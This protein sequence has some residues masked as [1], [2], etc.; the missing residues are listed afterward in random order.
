M[1][2]ERQRIRRRNHTRTIAD[3]RDLDGGARLVR[4][5]W[6]RCRRGSQSRR[7]LALAEVVSA[8]G[9]AIAATEC[10]AGIA[11]ASGPCFIGRALARRL[12]CEALSNAAAD[13][14]LRSDYGNPFD[15]HLFTGCQRA[16]LAHIARWGHR[17]ATRCAE[18]SVERPGTR[19]GPASRRRACAGASPDRRPAAAV[20]RGYA[21]DAVRASS[22]DEAT[23]GREFAEAGYDVTR[24]VGGQGILEAQ[25]LA[26]TYVDGGND[27]AAL[28]R[29]F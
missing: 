14:T 4:R 17:R 22:L 20:R 19:F 23:V 21:G 25:A 9:E 11:P 27:P 13:R 7:L 29:G 26:Q 28:R 6:T 24:V 5:V 15:V 10:V 18:V 1:A 8:L 12:R 2:R 3:Y 16:P